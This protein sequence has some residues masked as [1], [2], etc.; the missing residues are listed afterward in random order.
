MCKIKR[1]T[2]PIPTYEEQ[3]LITL[4]RLASRSVQNVAKVNI[5]QPTVSEEFSKFLNCLQNSKASRFSYMPLQENYSRIK[6][7]FTSLLLFRCDSTLRA[8]DRSHIPIIKPSLNEHLLV[9]QKSYQS[10]YY[11]YR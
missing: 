1:K 2:L 9:N 10:L 5:A 8:I 4:K 3:V 6:K 7:I 11:I